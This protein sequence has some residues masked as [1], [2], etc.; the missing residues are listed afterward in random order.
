M[1]NLHHELQFGIKN[2]MQWRNR[3]NYKEIGSVYASKLVT[4]IFYRRY[5]TNLIWQSIMQFANHEVKMSTQDAQMYL[6]NLYQSTA[7][8]KVSPII[9]NWLENNPN[10]YVGGIHLGGFE[11]LIDDASRGDRTAI[12][13]LEFDYLYYLLSDMCCVYWASICSSG[14]SKIDAI[15]QMTGFI[16]QPMPLE[17]YDVIVNGLGQLL[18]AKYLEENYTPLP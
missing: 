8:H 13:E 12:E 2:I 1:I 10:I 17:D 6:M 4:N 14:V 7:V 15:A 3:Y 18:V 16:I 5:T 11:K 9:E